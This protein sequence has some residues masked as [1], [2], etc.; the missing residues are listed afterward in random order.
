MEEQD[1]QQ[2]DRIVNIVRSIK[3][4]AQE[5]VSPVKEAVRNLFKTP[6]PRGRPRKDRTIDRSVSSSPAP[7]STATRGRPRKDRTMDRSVSS[8]PAPGYSGTDDD[9]TPRRN[10]RPRQAINYDF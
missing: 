8:S 2:E 3:K 7:P 6:A 9:G 5:I 1:D 4:E 10:L